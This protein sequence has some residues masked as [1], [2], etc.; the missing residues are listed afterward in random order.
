MVGQELAQRDRFPAFAG[1]LGEVAD[2]RRVEPELALLD[3][4]HHRGGGG[5]DLG[6]RGGVEDRVFG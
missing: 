6:E 2:Q 4:F 3:Q 5:D 1:E